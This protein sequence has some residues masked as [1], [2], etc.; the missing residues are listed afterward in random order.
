MTIQISSILSGSKKGVRHSNAVR[1]LSTSQMSCKKHEATTFLLRVLKPPGFT[2][3][4]SLTS[5]RQS[6]RVH[7]KECTHLHARVQK[8]DAQNS[9]P[10]WPVACIDWK[11]VSAQPDEHCSPRQVLSWDTWEQGSTSPSEPT[12]V[13]PSAPAGQWT[14]GG[15]PLH[16]IIFTIHCASAGGRPPSIRTLIG[17]P[18]NFSTPCQTLLARPLQRHMELAV[19][20]ACIQT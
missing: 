7:S 10:E 12:G 6:E 11:A 8:A 20:L 9:S 19:V 14:A 16:F 2:C 5:S 17:L 3:Q 4:Q 18:P 1:R 15:S 13:E